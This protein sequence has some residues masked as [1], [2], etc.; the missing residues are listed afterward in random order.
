LLCP[1]DNVGEP[2]AHNKPIGDIK[3]KLERL[4]EQANSSPTGAT[5]TN[6]CVICNVNACTPCPK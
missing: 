3:Q 5:G 2:P 4:I 6:T 1:T